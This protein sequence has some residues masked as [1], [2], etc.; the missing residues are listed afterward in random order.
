MMRRLLYAVCGAAALA[1]VGCAQPAQP[2]S[3][4]EV[5]GP[6][7]MDVPVGPRPGPEAV[8]EDDGSRPEPL[9]DDDAREAGRRYFVHYNCSGCHGDHGGGG[10]GPSLRDAMWLYG[11]SSQ[12]IAKSIAEGRNHGMP[13]WGR[14]LT[15]EQVWHL[16]AYLKSLRTPD[17]PQPPSQ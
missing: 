8:D 16:A 15:D 6:A 3:Q 1:C 12:H 5:V 7:A 14:M 17:E 13:A 10:M 9:H 2:V 4:P 11:N